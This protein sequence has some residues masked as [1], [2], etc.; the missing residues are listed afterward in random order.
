MSLVLIPRQMSVDA[1]GTP[2]VA[3]EWYFYAA[4]TNNLLQL[5]TT[6]DMDV[7]LANPVVSDGNG[8]FAA[9]YINEHAHPTHKQVMLDADGLTIFTEDNIPTVQAPDTTDL[10]SRDFLSDD[11][12]VDVEGYTGAEDVTASLQDAFDTAWA[13]QTALTVSR[14]THL[15][16][17]IEIP[18][19][20]ANRE[21]SMIFRG[22]GMGEV[23]DTTVGGGTIFKGDGTDAPVLADVSDS[24]NTGNG[25]LDASLFRVE[26]NSATE[27]AMDFDALYAQSHLHDFAIKQYGDG[28]GL[29][30]RQANT[31]HV[32]NG[33]AINADWN[34]SSLGLART[35]IGV[36]I[37]NTI[38]TGL[39]SV[40]KFTS[41]GWLTAYHIGG[42]VGTHYGQMLSQ[43]ECSITYN[44]VVLGTN[45]RAQNVAFGYFEGGDGGI[46]YHDQGNY[47]R[48]LFS[49]MFSGYG[50]AV[51]M[52]S[53]GTYGNLALG[54]VVSAASVAN[55][56][57]FKI[58]S[59]GALGGPAKFAMFNTLTFSGSGGTSFTASISGTTMTVSAF[60]SGT[61]L[62]VGMSVGANGV[63]DGTYIT[64]LGSGSGGT[65]TY[66][67]SLAQTV[68]STAMTAGSVAG[69]VGFTY[70]GIDPVVSSYF[71]AFDGR[72][73]WLGTSTTKKYDDQ[74]TSSDGTTG[75]GL[76]GINH[77]QDWDGQFTGPSLRR[78]AINLHVDRGVIDEQFLS[79]GVLTLGEMSIFTLTFTTPVTVQ[80]FAA[81]NL[82]DKTFETFSTNANGTQEHGTWI[83]LLGGQNFTPDAAGAWQKWQ[84][85]PGGIVRETAR[86]CYGRQQIPG[87]SGANGYANSLILGS[88]HIWVDSTGDLR[89]KSTVPTSDTDGT[90]VGTQT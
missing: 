2:R 35:G 37:T 43:F 41:R 23:F 86:V 28:G 16:S 73:R 65:G 19:A 50:T 81:P 39:F 31:S 76:I 74:S 88:A 55:T 46:G 34:T 17:G 5:W 32:F 83:K 78:G 56:K 18:R 25:H 57:L 87:A 30:I 52:S 62:A 48:L 14:G 38:D 69:V 9:V 4:G 21:R 58:G 36:H 47:N 33:H 49:I 53:A 70:T 79:G 72:G 45:V 22:Q 29:R 3:A 40:H 63:R 59:S 27:A 26:A 12:L 51:D 89:I 42:G 10:D 61:P 1:N 85:L 20:A 6:S 84:V 67:V 64:A 90:V 7:E 54:N 82:P 24:A 44:G 80:R 8:H 75:S 71:N 13:E 68:S 11:E 66:T 60:G 15:T 77:A